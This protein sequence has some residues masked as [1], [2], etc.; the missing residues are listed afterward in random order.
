[1]VVPLP[2]CGNMR[3]RVAVHF[4]EPASDRAGRRHRE[5][6]VTADGEGERMLAFQ[7]AGV[8]RCDQQRV[9]GDRQWQHTEAPRPPL[10]YELER[11]PAHLGEIGYGDVES[12]RY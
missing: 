12:R 5:A 7:V 3:L 6:N 2:R 11:L 10:G 1:V 9:I 8:A 4:V